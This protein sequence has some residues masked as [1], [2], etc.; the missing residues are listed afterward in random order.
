VLLYLTENALTERNCA[1][2]VLPGENFV[3]GLFVH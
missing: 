2:D 3:S 1:Q